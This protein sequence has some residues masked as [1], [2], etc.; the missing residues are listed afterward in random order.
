MTEGRD[1]GTVVFPAA[2]CKFFLTASEDERARRR[3][4]DLEARGERATLEEILAAQRR[5]DRE[6]AARPVGPLLPAAGRHPRLHRRPDAGRSRGSAGI[7]GPP[8]V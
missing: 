4:R 1:Q 7:A 6:D 3:L 5:R 8:A 2:E